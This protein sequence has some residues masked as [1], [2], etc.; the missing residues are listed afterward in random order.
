MFLRAA[1]KVSKEHDSAQFL[2]VGKGV[3]TKN[4]IILEQVKSLNIES[5]VHLLGHRTDI[6]E[7]LPQ[8]SVFALTSICEGFPNV[9]GEAMACSVPCVTTDAGAMAEVLGDC[10]VVTPKGDAERFAAALLAV[11]AKSQSERIVMGERARQRVQEHFS[12]DSITAKYQEAYE[13]LSA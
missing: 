8:L 13:Q 10:G 7:L 11:L 1:A 2:L 3:D 12:L 4:A 6:D 9:V 5:R